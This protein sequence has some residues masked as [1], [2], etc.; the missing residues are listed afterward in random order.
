MDTSA[1]SLESCQNCD[2]AILPGQNYCP[3]CGQKAP[4]PRLTLHEISAEFVHALA[5]VDRSALSLIWQ[6]LIRPGVVA[7]DFVAGKRK[8]YFGPFAFLVV[9]VAFTSAVIAI[10]GFQAVTADAPNGFATFLQQHIN[11]LFFF[12]VPLLAAACRLMGIREPFNY[13]EYLVLTSYSGGLHSLFYALVVIP[14]WYVLR[15]DTVLLTRLFYASLSFGPLYL[16]YGM[17]QFLPGRRFS[18]AIKGLFAS[19]LTQA[20]T[21]GLV[22]L[23]GYLYL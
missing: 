12:D 18:S 22:I 21:Q 2:S 1:S 5:H 7:R 10:S 13:A 19:L 6:L 3:N 20:A 23:I 14:V 15:S 4:T 11:L 16:A 8:R 17:Y 9:T